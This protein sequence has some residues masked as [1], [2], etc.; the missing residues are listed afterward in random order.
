MN[1]NIRFNLDEVMK[2]KNMSVNKLSRI[3]GVS[4]TYISKLKSG[5]YTNPTIN[6]V[7][8]L[9][10]ALDVKIDELITYYGE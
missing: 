10:K 1:D 3:S 8:S 4:R 6:I 2:E 5:V 9:A 7:Y